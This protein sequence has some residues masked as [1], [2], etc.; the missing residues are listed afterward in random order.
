[1]GM[2]LRVLG[3][4]VLGRNGA[5]F[6]LAFALAQ[7]NWL[8]DKPLPDDVIASAIIC[9]DGAVGPVGEIERKLNHARCSGSTL[10]RFFVAEGSGA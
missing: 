5:S 9:H 2:W 8:I 3:A 7:V 1:M 10:R 6:G 4:G